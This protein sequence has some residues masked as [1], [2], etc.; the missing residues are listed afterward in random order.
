MAVQANLQ[1][2]QLKAISTSNTVVTS[3]PIP[4][5]VQALPSNGLIHAV[6]P[7]ASAKDP[8][9][10]VQ[11]RVVPATQTSNSNKLNQMQ[12]PVVRLIKAS[13]KVS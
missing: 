4:T 12:P 5:T 2:I 10:Q 13:N 6:F 3:N 11:L 1:Q 8:S 7:S 9:K